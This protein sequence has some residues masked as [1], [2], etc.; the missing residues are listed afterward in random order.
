M[1]LLV[2]CCVPFSL[3]AFVINSFFTAQVGLCRLDALAFVDWAHWCILKRVK[4]KWMV[5]LVFHEVCLESNQCNFEDFG[6]AG[7]HK[8]DL[9]TPVNLFF[10]KGE[11][12]GLFLLLVN[13]VGVLK[14][15][16]LSD[17]Q[18]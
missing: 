12:L 2:I 9:K 1:S 5:A 17:L 4:K 11:A 7:S 3:M 15:S 13:F 8:A 14:L 16:R 6:M 18:G 10:L